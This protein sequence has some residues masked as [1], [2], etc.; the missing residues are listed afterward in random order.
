VLVYARGA[1]CPFCLRQ[2]A[3]YAE[4]YTDFNRSGVEVVALSP[5]TPR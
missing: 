5:E 1:W 2:L 4:R 3:D